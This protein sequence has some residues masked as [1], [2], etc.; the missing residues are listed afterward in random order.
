MF[1]KISRYRNEPEEVTVDAK[2]RVLA[3]KRL[4]LLPQATGQFLHSIEEGDRLDHLAFKYYKQPRSWWQIADANPAFIS[5]HTMLGNEPLTE[6]IFNIVWQGPT[7]PWSRLLQVLRQER[8]IVD[9]RLG[10]E[11]MRQAEVAFTTASPLFQS[12]DAG[13]VSALQG[14]ADFLRPDGPAGTRITEND[15]I[16]LFSNTLS[17]QGIVLTGSLSLI[18][19]E[20]NLW[21]VIEEDT[22]RLFT[23][24]LVESASEVL[25][26]DTVVES[27]WSL[28]ITFNE[29]LLL[30]TDIDHLIEGYELIE[31][32][33]R[34]FSDV[35]STK[36]QR[37]GKSIV[38][39]PTA[40]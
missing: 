28:T 6:G 39:P 36:L 26:F 30:N 22:N 16:V 33:S 3:S 18:V 29:A 11:A 9:V 13:L 14:L 7:P 1:S 38:I 32:D 21:R 27:S 23:F 2:G 10:T 12:S 25:V 31:G 24:S 40:I 17:G 34:R 4:R 37:V 8:G 19:T 20:V 35:A 15:L 5:P